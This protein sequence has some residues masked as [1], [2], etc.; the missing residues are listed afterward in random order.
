MDDDES[1]SQ[2]WARGREE[3]DYAFGLRLRACSEK[4][5]TTLTVVGHTNLPYPAQFTSSLVS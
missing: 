2:R 1:E 4:Q 5:G 3:R